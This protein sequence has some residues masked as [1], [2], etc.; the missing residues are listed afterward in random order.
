[1]LSPR[2][3]FFLICSLLLVACLPQDDSPPTKTSNLQPAPIGNLVSSPPVVPTADNLLPLTTATT[4]NTNLNPTSTPPQPTAT[5]DLTTTPTCT[6]PTDWITYQVQPGDILSVLAS[7]TNTTTN[8][9]ININCLTNPNRLEPGQTL[10]LPQIPQNI[11]PTATNFPPTPLPPSPNNT[12]TYQ[13]PSRAY[14]FD[15]PASWTPLNGNEGFGDGTYAFI[16]G[17]LS[18]GRNLDDI[19]QEAANHTLLPYGPNPIITPV[20]LNNGYPARTIRAANPNT[21]GRTPAALIT[22]L[23]QQPDTINYL[24]IDTDAAYL[25]LLINTLYTPPIPETMTINQFNVTTTY[26]PALNITFFDFSWDTSGALYTRITVQ[27]SDI[28]VPFTNLGPRGNIAIGKDIPLQNATISLHAHHA[29][30]GRI[31]STSIPL[32]LTCLHTNHFNADDIICPAN[33]VVTLLAAQ[34]P[35]EHGHMY[36]LPTP[37]G[38]LIFVLMEDGSTAVFTDDWLNNQE[39]PTNTPTPPAGYHMPV[40]GFGLVWRNNPHISNALGW[41]TTPEGQLPVQYQA[42]LS[43]EIPNTWFFTAANT[44]TYIRTTKTNWVQY[45]LP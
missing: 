19:T 28:V 39:E 26:D 14:S 15:Y 27:A 22:F 1:M 23:H 30:N 6:P 10:Y 12:T 40:R 33:P 29:L 4:I 9:L 31:K 20:T 8:T 25:D 16:L 5:T 13:H 44:N 38:N 32:D 18:A 45:N 41:A 43:P 42:N 2:S 21:S 17:H 11:P 24:Q 3:L 34:Q 7:R 36:W 35:F 37:E